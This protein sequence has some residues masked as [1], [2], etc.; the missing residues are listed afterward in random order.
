MSRPDYFQEV[1]KTKQYG[2]REIPVGRFPCTKMFPINADDKAYI[3]IA[4]NVDRI[5]DD[6]RRMVSKYREIVGQ[7][8]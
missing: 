2:N 8:M 6:Q 5:P 3:K 7:D 4:R 1:I